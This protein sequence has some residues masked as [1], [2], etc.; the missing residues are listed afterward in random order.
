MDQ[1]FNQYGKIITS[2][3]GILIAISMVVAAGAIVSAA[4]NEG[5]EIMVENA[6]SVW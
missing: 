2:V 6:R 1:I 3:I 4:L 5:L